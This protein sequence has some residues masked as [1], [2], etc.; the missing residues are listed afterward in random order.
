MDPLKIVGVVIAALLFAIAGHSSFGM[1][2]LAIGLFIGILVA[3]GVVKLVRAPTLDED[4]AFEPAPFNHVEHDR[5]PPKGTETLTL[6]Q[7]GRGIG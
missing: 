6:V 4:R 7:G 2:G 5:Q 3:F 1:L